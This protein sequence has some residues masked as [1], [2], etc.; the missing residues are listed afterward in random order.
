V[1][2]SGSPELR[3]L[4]AE[5]ESYPAPPPGASD[6]AAVA[7]VLE[8]ATADGD[9]LTFLSTVTTFGTAL[10]PTAAELSMETF[11]PAD[12]ATAAALVCLAAAQGRSSR[13]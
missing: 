11:L 4:A 1:S 7:V 12:D 2:A 5:L 8:I 9:P 13:E 3:A 10:D 6:P